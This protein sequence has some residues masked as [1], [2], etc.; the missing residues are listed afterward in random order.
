MIES[1]KCSTLRL[2]KSANAEHEI[3]ITKLITIVGVR[4]ARGRYTR[5]AVDVLYV[6]SHS[7]CEAPAWEAGQLITVSSGTGLV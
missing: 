4:S 2:I 6:H 7:D 1:S 3:A 5:I